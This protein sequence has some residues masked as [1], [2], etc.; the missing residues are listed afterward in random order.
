[1][2][3]M[4]TARH[5]FRCLASATT[6]TTGERALWP[7]TPAALLASPSTTATRGGLR[8][9]GASRV[10]HGT[11]CGLTF[12]YDALTLSDPIGASDGV[13]RRSVDYVEVVEEDGAQPLDMVGHTQDAEGC[14]GLCAARRRSRG[15]RECTSYAW[16]GDADGECYLRTDLV[17]DPDTSAAAAGRVSGRPWH[18]G[19]DNPAPWIDP[20]TGKVLALYRTYSEGGSGPTQR[21]LCAQRSGA[22]G[23]SL[24]GAAAA[25][26]WQGPYKML[27]GPEGGPI[28]TYQYPYEE[29][30]D[31]FLWRTKRGWHL[32]AHANTWSDSKSHPWPVAQYAGRYAYSLDG[33]AWHYSPRAPF[34]GTVAW[35]NGTTA[36]F[37]R[38]ERPFLLFHHQTHRPTHLLT[39]VQRYAWDEYT[40]SLVQELR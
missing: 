30:E 5:S 1:M 40:F 9:K 22:C 26:S 6:F 11:P 28:S 34:S 24:I 12:S 10:R 3:P 16:H 15:Q 32:L 23:A 33:T 31:P 8:V 25:P 27:E 14:R 38:R 21:M 13:V 4:A 2:R 18:Y 37:A 29:N 7:G 17:W 36:V 39:G 19:G 35:R 20:E